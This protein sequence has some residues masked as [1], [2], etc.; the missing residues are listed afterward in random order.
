MLYFNQSVRWLSSN[1]QWLEV[2]L[3][4]S[5]LCDRSAWCDTA[6]KLKPSLKQR[7]YSTLVSLCAAAG[8]QRLM[9]RRAEITRGLAF[10]S[11]LRDETI[12]YKSSVTS[13]TILEILPCKPGL[14][15]KYCETTEISRNKET[16]HS[17]F[18]TMLQAKIT[19]P[20]LECWGVYFTGQSLCYSHSKESDAYC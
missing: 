3:S 4:L 7:L 6:E 11:E 17:S 20:I 8:L 19:A 13:H 2:P 5:A 14:K 16:R 15:A 1:L 10:I 12:D 9:V 18:N